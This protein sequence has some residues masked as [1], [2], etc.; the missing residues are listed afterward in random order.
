M[1]YELN[2]RK[3]QATYD[4]IYKLQKTFAP[5]DHD[6]IL[7]SHE[8]IAKVVTLK[9]L[10]PI[11]SKLISVEVFKAISDSLAKV[12]TTGSYLDLIDIPISEGIV[13]KAPNG[14]YWKLDT[15]EDGNLS[16]SKLSD[17]EILKSL[18][19]RYWKLV[20]NDDKSVKLVEV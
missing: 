14:D 11:M 18:N 12:A 19:G 5:Y 15:D 17:G 13:L 9:E 3:A 2:L 10:A 8:G 1:D 6:K 16:V 20:I 4:D 7:I